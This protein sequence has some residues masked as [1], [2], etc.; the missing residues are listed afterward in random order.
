MKSI[1]FYRFKKK[2]LTKA[3]TIIPEKSVDILEEIKYKKLFQCILKENQTILL[4]EKTIVEI[5]WVFCLVQLT[6]THV[7]IGNIYGSIKIIDL[8]TGSLLYTLDVKVFSTISRLLKFN[9]KL[10]VSG[11][12]D[13]TI[14]LW[15]F[16][17]GE[18]ITSFKGHTKRITC[19][20]MIKK[21]HIISSSEDMTFKLWDLQSGK[22]IKTLIFWN[23]GDYVF[24]TSVIKV[25]KVS[26]NKLNALNTYIIASGN[27][28]NSKLTKMWDLNTEKCLNT[29]DRDFCHTD[30]ITSIVK[31]DKFH[32]ASGSNDNTIKIWDLNTV[33]CLKTLLG[34]TKLVSTLDKINRSHLVSGSCDKS[35]KLWDFQIGICLKTFIVKFVTSIHKLN[36]YQITSLSEYNTIK[37][38][39]LYD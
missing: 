21:T 28:S 31:L 30:F 14:N 38:W 29:F 26:S 35:I 6:K 8:S 22:C 16:N 34:H 17:T 27:F 4:E 13:G 36:R 12:F 1:P 7:A 2:T 15:D 3:Y 39:D 5:K 10:L 19:L 37:I 20:E 11:Y 24:L 33:T 18:F 25:S 23:V 32:I 9:S